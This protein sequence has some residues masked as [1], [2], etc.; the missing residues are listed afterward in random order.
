M[1]CQFCNS[2]KKKETLKVESKIDNNIYNYYV[3]KKCGS[4]YQY[5]IPTKQDIEKYYNNYYQIKQQINPGYLTEK[6]RENFFKERDRTL[7]DIKFPFKRI[8]EKNNFELGCANGEFLLYLKQNGGENITGLDI[9]KTLIDSININ[10]INLL[11]GDLSLLEDK[12]VDNL[13]LFNVLEHTSIKDTLDNIVRVIKNDSIIVIEIPLAGFIS[14]F[15]KEK[16]RFFI[17]NEHLNI[18]TLK[19]FKILLRKYNLKIIKM[20]RFGSGLTSGM[21][22]PL[23]KKIFDFLAK[24]FSFGDRG[25]FLLIVKN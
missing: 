16:W 2:N 14:N 4:I 6:H 8:A 3:C 25:S 15:F 11:N 18:P 19:G 21:K 24:K 13:Y 1:V 23:I 17:P 20:E 22:N 9:S 10:D 12:S 7:K 5:P